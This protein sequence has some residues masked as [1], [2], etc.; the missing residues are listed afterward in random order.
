MF[1]AEMNFEKAVLILAGILIAAFLAVA[2]VGC[3]R[4]CTHP[5]V[6]IDEFPAEEM[7][8][9]IYGLDSWERETNGQVHFTFVFVSHAQAFEMAQDIPKDDS[10]F[11][12]RQSAQQNAFCPPGADIRAGAAGETHRKRWSGS[13]ALCFDADMINALS[14]GPHPEL[15]A[16]ANWA[17]IGAHEAGHALKMEHDP[18]PVS[19]M[20][21]Q[22]TNTVEYDLTCHDIRTLVDI[23]GLDLPAKCTL[24]N[25][26][27]ATARSLSSVKP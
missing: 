9:L 21:P 15:G 5:T 26:L 13:A 12:V 2:L 8:P 24:E 27:L 22:S 7:A 6:Y 25:S 20:F 4:T 1:F 17:T 14:N 23:W 10:L 18:L 16:W 19:I 11:I 3:D